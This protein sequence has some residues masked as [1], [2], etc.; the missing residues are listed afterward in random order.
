MK[1]TAK[2]ARGTKT[3]QAA[4]GQIHPIVIYPFKQPAHDADLEALYGLVADWPRNREVTPGLSRSWTA[5]LITPWKAIGAFLDFR[6]NTVARHSEILDAWCVDTCQ[7]WYEGLGAAF[8]RG[9]D[10]DVYWLIPGDFNYGTAA[11]PGSAGP[12]A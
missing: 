6:N 2:T 8:E 11:G 10:N 7:M 5:K 1:K 12:P 4:A 9:A 3:S